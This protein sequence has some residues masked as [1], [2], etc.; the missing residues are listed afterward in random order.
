MVGCKATT[1]TAFF[2]YGLNLIAGIAEPQHLDNSQTI[3]Q[4]KPT[5]KRW[6]VGAG[7][8]LRRVA[9]FFVSA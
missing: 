9:Y 8:G 2:L 7:L 1:L 3:T 6:L 4:N 5:L